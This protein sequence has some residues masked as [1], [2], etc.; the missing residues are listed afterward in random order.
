V[1]GSGPE[2]C[3][4]PAGRKPNKQGGIRPPQASSARRCLKSAETSQLGQQRRPDQM[5][6]LGQSTPRGTAG[7]QQPFQADRRPG[8]RQ[9]HAPAHDQGLRSATIWTMKLWAVVTVCPRSCRR[10]D[11]RCSY[12]APEKTRSPAP[13]GRPKDKQ[14]STGEAASSPLDF[15]SKNVMQASVRQAPLMQQDRGP[16]RRSSDTRASCG[17]AATSAAVDGHPLPSGVEGGLRAEQQSCCH[18]QRGSS[19]GQP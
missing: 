1:I 3:R 7:A 5:G 10:A 12:P 2:A 16:E 13:E 17:E 15:R 6:P 11:H 19:N 4:A 8:P 14:A 9:G 18:Q